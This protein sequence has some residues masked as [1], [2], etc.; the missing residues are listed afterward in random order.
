[1]GIVVSTS[2]G[3]GD[4][5]QIEEFHCSLPR[6]SSRGGGVSSY[7]VGDLITDP[8]E[9]VETRGGILEYHSDLCAENRTTFACGHREKI[10]T[11]PLG[12]AHDP[13]VGGET[14]HRQHRDAF[15]RT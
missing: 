4:T 13:S 11:L 6:R 10:S 3:G 9:W 12:A 1:M 7:D 2:A 8:S 15:S 5:H 14:K